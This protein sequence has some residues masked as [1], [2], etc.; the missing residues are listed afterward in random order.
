MHNRTLWLLAVLFESV[1]FESRYLC[2]TVR[3]VS[4]NCDKIQFFFAD[5]SRV[6]IQELFRGV[7]LCKVPRLT[8]F[9]YFQL[10]SIIML[11]HMTDFKSVFY[12]HLILACDLPILTSD[13]SV[14]TS[15]LFLGVPSCNP[16]CLFLYH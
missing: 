3:I 9:S 4:T 7:S 2:C 5:V 11:S 14:C 1:L 8:S 13:A 16:P 15:L 6:Y 12:S 10:V